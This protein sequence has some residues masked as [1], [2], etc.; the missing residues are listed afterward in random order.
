M[1]VEDVEE[2]GTGPYDKVEV[3]ATEVLIGSL[4]DDSVGLGTGGNV[5][6]PPY[7]DSV[8]TIGEEEV[9]KAEDS[10]EAVAP[11]ESTG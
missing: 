9:L 5:Y 10:E 4:E 6:P 2:G 3:L 11:V 1:M 8:V 7:W